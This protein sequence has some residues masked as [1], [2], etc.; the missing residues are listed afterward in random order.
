MLQELPDESRQ[1]R[2][3]M[4]IA[5]IHVLVVDHTPINENN[6]MIENIEAY[7]YMWQHY[8]L[9]EKEPAG[10][11]DKITSSKAGQHTPT[12]DLQK[13]TC[14]MPETGVQLMCAASYDIWCRYAQHK[15]AAART[16]WKDVCLTSRT[17]TK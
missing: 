2:M 17:R 3:N 16:K 4:N 5:K 13:Q 12:R 6:A 14:Y 15:L 10:Q 1:I 11:R 9:E 8:S 7:K